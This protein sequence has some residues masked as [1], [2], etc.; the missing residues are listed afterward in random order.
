[1]P[2]NQTVFILDDDDAVRDSLE[3]LL[4]S[5][6]FMTKPYASAYAFLDEVTASKNGCLILDIRMPEM[7]GLDVQDCLSKRNI[8][9]PVIIITGHG[10][11]PM[12]VRA[13]K[14][15][16]LDFIE[17]P[18]DEDGL[19]KAVRRALDIGG[20]IYKDAA[21]RDNLAK[22]I[23]KLTPREYEVLVQIASGH[24]NKVVAF[25]LGISPRTVEIHRARVSEKMKARNLSH[26]VRMAIEAGILN[27][28]Q[29]TAN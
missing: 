5:H 16:A 2:D 28:G 8:S 23:N 14:G 15:G 25:E 26:L 22:R 13:M 1:M 4:E 27:L 10:D 11:L 24:P 17:K 29:P 6:G 12:A 20:K 21:I 3:A 9:L 7:N 18:F 19:L